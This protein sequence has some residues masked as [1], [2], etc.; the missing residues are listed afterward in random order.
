[1]LKSGLDRNLFSVLIQ[2]H[3]KYGEVIGAAVEYL[4]MTNG[5]QQ[6]TYICLGE[7]GPSS[8]RAR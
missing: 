5:M 1:M 6:A 7:G 8:T 2:V 3:R 4:V